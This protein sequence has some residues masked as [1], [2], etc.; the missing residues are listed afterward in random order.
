HREA[1]D[2]ALK[3]VLGVHGPQQFVVAHP[4]VEATHNAFEGGAP[5]DLGPEA[6]ADDVTALAHPDLQVHDPPFGVLGAFGALGARGAGC[7][8]TTGSGDVLGGRAPRIEPA[9]SKPDSTIELRA[10]SRM[11]AVSRVRL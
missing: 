9:P 7:C 4:L 1:P 6:G 11:P 10:G 3:I 2:G 5:A 8:A